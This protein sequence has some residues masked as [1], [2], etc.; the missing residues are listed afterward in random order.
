[1]A[2][3]SLII[4]LLL[5]SILLGICSASAGTPA[6]RTPAFGLMTKASAFGRRI[7][8][9]SATLE[10]DVSVPKSRASAAK[11]APE[12]AKATPQPPR[13]AAQASKE[14]SPNPLSAIPMGM[15]V[16]LLGVS[17]T[18]PVNA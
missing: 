8:Q 1:M 11:A 14:C 18:L 3:R 16:F 5:A 2:S 17:L 4:L 9:R 10:K 12:P 15:G 13:G 7:M 6:L